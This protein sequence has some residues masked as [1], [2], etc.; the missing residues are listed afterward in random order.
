MN[1]RLKGLISAAI[2]FSGLLALGSADAWAV[3]ISSD[4]AASTEGLGTF[5]GTLTYTSGSATTGQLVI[6]L[7]NTSPVGNSGFIT[8]FALNNPGGI[9]S[10]S[11]IL[12]GDTDFQQ[13]GLSTN[14]VSASP[15][16]DFDFGAALGGNFL[17]G[18]NPNPG[19]GVGASASFTFNLSGSNLNLLTENSFLTALSSGASAGNDAES[20]IVRFRGFSDGGSDKVPTATTTPSPV[21]VPEPGSLAL[22]GA[23]LAGLGLLLRRKSS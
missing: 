20:V 22:F 23:A 11:S 1:M 12:F 16:G 17:G 7:T 3:S 15:F 19:I 14:G 4:S 18:G 2:A 21:G 10:I 9:T 6:S 13:L 8:G 5:T